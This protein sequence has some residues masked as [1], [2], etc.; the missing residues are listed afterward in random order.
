M[1]ASVDDNK[2]RQQRDF[3]HLPVIFYAMNAMKIIS[4]CF[5]RFFYGT[6]KSLKEFF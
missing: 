2:K 4:L 1:H 3:S 5:Y 6:R